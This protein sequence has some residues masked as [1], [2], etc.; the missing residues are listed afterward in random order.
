MEKERLLRGTA[1]LV[2]LASTSTMFGCAHH[3]EVNNNRGNIPGYYIRSEMQDSDRALDA[4]RA[5]GKDKACPAEFKDAEDAKNK[6]YDWY[7]LCH[8]EEGAAMAKK[9]TEKANALC[10]PKAEAQPAALAPVAEPV[11]ETPVEPVPAAEP[12][13]GHY[14]YCITLHGE[15][16]I[17]RAQIR[18]EYRD[19]VAVVGDFM[20]K[21]P[22]TTAVI[23]GHSDNVGSPEHNMEL[24]TRRAEAVVNYLVENYG[25]DRSRLS[26]RGLG[27]SRPVADNAT[28]AGRQKNR[29]IEAII[30]C[31]FE[32]KEVQP[33]ERL[34]MSLVVDFDNG[35]SDI[36]AQYRDEFAKVG[37]YLNKYPTTTAVIEGHT[38]NVGGY[39]YNMKLSLERAQHVVDYLATN[40][41]ID[42]SRLAAKGYGYTR[43]VAYNNTA[44]GRAK[45]R[46][47]NAIIDCVITK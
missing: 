8:T 33:P 1:L 40:F 12:V 37:E 34:C 36:K 35:K 38:D 13:P 17:D 16:D 41:G 29:R 4:A 28:D 26:A 47:I 21:Y 30:D 24:S 5:A 7:R 2:A 15:Y 43:R 44:E 11:A 22:T 39:D 18:P 3:Y 6:A 23:E 25:I 32:V 46:R 31:V 27:M 9:A 45:N 20:K 10:P 19:E 14:K 42:R